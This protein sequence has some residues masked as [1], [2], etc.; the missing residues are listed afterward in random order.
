MKKIISL[1]VVCVLLV[2]TML[3]LASCGLSGTYEAGTT[4]LEF[5]GKKVT[6]TEEAEVFGAKV[7]KTYEAEYKVEEDDDGEKTIT[8]TYAEDDDKHLILNGEKTFS[9]GE[10]D[11]KKY[12]K[13]GLIT[14]YKAD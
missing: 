10:E 4:T 1:M 14:Y 12:I 13:I 3:T 2:G 8:F 9:Q 6:I 11:G 5:S 7:S